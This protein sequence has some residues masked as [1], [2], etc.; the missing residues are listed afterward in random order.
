M[1]DITVARINLNYLSDGQRIQI[2]DCFLLGRAQQRGAGGFI[3]L[4]VFA[5]RRKMLAARIVGL[6]DPLRVKLAI[7]IAVGQILVS[8]IPR[9]VSTIAAH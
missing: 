5:S 7:A 2:G 1:L 3:P 8:L 4:G 6:F 9:L